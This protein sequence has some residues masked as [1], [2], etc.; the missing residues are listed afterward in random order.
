MLRATDRSE[1]RYFK[2][3]EAVSSREMTFDTAGGTIWRYSTSIAYN[4]LNTLYASGYAAEIED[5][6]DCI[7]TGLL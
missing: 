4:R 2:A 5:F 3:S 6:A 1:L 7:R